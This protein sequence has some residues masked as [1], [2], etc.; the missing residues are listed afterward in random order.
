MK[1]GIEK[2]LE[3]F[4]TDYNLTD[5][6]MN[7]KTHNCE[8]RKKEIIKEFMDKIRVMMAKAL[9]SKD[10]LKFRGGKN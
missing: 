3:Q 9:C 4:S 8:H 1:P 6:I 7:L 2:G 5:I 10:G